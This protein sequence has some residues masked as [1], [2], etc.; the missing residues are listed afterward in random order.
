MFLDFLICI[1]SYCDFNFLALSFGCYFCSYFC[2]YM[3][4]SVRLCTVI[5]WDRHGNDHAYRICKFEHGSYY[6]WYFQLGET[7]KNNRTYKRFLNW[8]IVVCT[9]NNIFIYLGGRTR[10][11]HAYHIG[12]PNLCPAMCISSVQ[13]RFFL[14]FLYL[15]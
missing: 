7:S 4:R 11:Y 12:F 6:W 14:N 13:N 2:C 1:S 3:W 8:S 5:R 15:L 9:D 10:N